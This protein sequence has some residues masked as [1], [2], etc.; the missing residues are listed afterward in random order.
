MAR[1]FAER[2]RK[3]AAEAAAAEME[4]LSLLPVSYKEQ[5]FGAKAQIFALRPFGGVAR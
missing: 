5:V 1:L 2:L 3:T 4:Q